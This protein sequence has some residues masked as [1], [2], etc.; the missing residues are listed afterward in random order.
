[1]CTVGKLR[2]TPE[3]V[4][5][6]GRSD[7]S[8][9]DK[10]RRSKLLMERQRRL[11]AQRARTWPLMPAATLRTRVGREAFMPQQREATKGLRPDRTREAPT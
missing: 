3:G 4:F 11:R 10:D 5:V 7:L 2:E 6:P 1:M 9:A 8:S